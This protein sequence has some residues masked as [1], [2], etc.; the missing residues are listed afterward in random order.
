M[1]SILVFIFGSGAYLNIHVGRF[2][3]M[4]GRL[5]D[6]FADRYYPPD[7]SYVLD[8]QYLFY[9]IETVEMAY[10]GALFGILF[11]IPLSWFASFNMSPN[12][13]FLYPASRLFLM[14]CRSVHEMIWTIL[15][16]TIL[17]FGMLPGVLALTLFSIGFTGKLFSEEIE[18]IN[19]GQV[20]AIQA[21]GANPLQ[22]FI[23]AVLPQVRVCWTGISIYTW[24]AAFRA[25]TV[26]GFFGAGGMGWYLRR[27]VQQVETTRVATILLSIIVLVV[28]SEITSAWARNKVSGKTT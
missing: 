4:F 19:R 24:D 10:L 5:T 25:A 28:I 1:L 18:A 13:R 14:S 21:T 3:E 9:V 12:R 11:S 23:Y 26:V 6:L 27:T 16:V 7:I 20:E 22:V 8:G 2:L 15:F 17:G